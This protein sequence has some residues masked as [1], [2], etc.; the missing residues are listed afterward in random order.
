M[1]VVYL[2]YPLEVSTTRDFEVVDHQVIPL[3]ELGLVLCPLAPIVCT[4]FI[5]LA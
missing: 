5:N 2:D 3:F 4:C 1:L